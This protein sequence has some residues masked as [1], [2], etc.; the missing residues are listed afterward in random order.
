MQTNRFVVLNSQ[1]M[2]KKKACFVWKGHLNSHPCPSSERENTRGYQLRNVSIL[3]RI[4]SSH[5]LI[6]KERIL[7]N[8]IWKSICH[9]ALLYFPW[10][11]KSCS[12]GMC[13]VRKCYLN[14]SPITTH[15]CSQ[16]CW[17]ELDVLRNMNLEIIKEEIW[18]LIKKRKRTKANDMFT[19]SHQTNMHEW[20]NIIRSFAKPKHISEI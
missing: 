13:W 19:L 15:S 8:A 2:P 17:G 7:V 1:E 20:I 3:S 11:L 6:W 10:V 14:I 9:R 12:G 18:N 16:E 5:F 4:Y